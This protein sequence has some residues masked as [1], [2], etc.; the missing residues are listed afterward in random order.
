MTFSLK[1]VLLTLFLGLLFLSGYTQQTAN[2]VTITNQNGKKV[3]FK[4]KTQKIEWVNGKV[5]LAFT[6]TDG[7]LLQITNIAETTLKDTTFRSNAVMAVLITDSFTF[8]PIKRIAPLVEITCEGAKKGK[9]VSFIIQGSLFYAKNAY[10]YSIT[11]TG[12]LPEKKFTSTYRKNL[13]Q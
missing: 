8:K 1:K 6:S 12:V 9:E 11:Y 7:K 5:N 4:I 3:L 2:N 13:Q 10:R